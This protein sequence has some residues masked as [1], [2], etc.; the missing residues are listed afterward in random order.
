MARILLGIEVDVMEALSWTW[1]A[2]QNEHRVSMVNAQY[3]MAGR[4]QLL[5]LQL[6]VV[7][8]LKERVEESHLQR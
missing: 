2:N 8:R 5:L 1:A 7:A 4:R 3:S 6:S